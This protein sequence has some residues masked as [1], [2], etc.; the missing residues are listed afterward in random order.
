MN[1]FPIFI[2]LLTFVDPA[3]S[4]EISTERIFEVES[5]ISLP[6]DPG[7]NGDAELLGYDVDR[8]GVRDDIQRYLELRYFDEPKVKAVFYDYASSLLKRISVADKSREYIQDLAK[9][10]EPSFL[11][12]SWLDD[13][14]ERDYRSE[15]LELRK[16]VFNTIARYKANMLF[17]S[18]LAGTVTTAIDV[19]TYKSYCVPYGLGN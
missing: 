8:S 15:I 10:R 14:S 19:D 13:S 18:K 4:Y 17:H 9:K 3:L 16:R 2:L 6:P 12:L 11:C 7:P 1:P 5:H